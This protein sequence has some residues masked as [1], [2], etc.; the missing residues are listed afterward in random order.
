MSNALTSIKK[1]LTGGRIHGFTHV[2]VTVNDFEAAVKWYNEM[3]GFHLV[4]E[5]YIEGEAANALA[6][7]YGES[8]LKIRLGFLGTQSSGLIEIFEFQPKSAE[9]PTVWTRPGYT[10]CAISV[11]NV[12][13]V[14]RELEAKGVEFVTDVQFTN[15]AHW[16]FMKDLDGNFV[17]LIDYHVNRLPLAMVSNLVGRIMR[18]TEFGSYYE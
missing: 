10:H 11:S 1:A 18:K 6:G 9:A 2:G 14:K 17:E 8:G 13:A 12:K 16:A 4:N 3:F 5:M 7:L 15:G